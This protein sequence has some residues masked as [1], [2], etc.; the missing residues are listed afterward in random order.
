MQRTARSITIRLLMGHAIVIRW[1]DALLLAHLNSRSGVMPKVL[2][3]TSSKGSD[4]EH[5]NQCC[6]ES[7]SHD[8]SEF[9]ASRHRLGARVQS[10]AA[11]KSA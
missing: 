10:I 7:A 5:Q 9:G 11:L 4:I 2:S 3:S 8:G 6:F 1:L